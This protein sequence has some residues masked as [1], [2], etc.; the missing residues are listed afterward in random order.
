MVIISQYFATDNIHSNCAFLSSWFS[1][2]RVLIE[3][4]SLIDEEIDLIISNVLGRLRSIPTQLSQAYIF[5]DGHHIFSSIPTN[6]HFHQ[7]DKSELR[8]SV[9]SEYF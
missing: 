7:L 6:H 4:G 3:N 5:G 8:S 9:R 1:H 2:A